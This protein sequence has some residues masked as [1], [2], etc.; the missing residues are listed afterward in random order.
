M[1]G[2]IPLAPVAKLDISNNYFTLANMPNRF[3]L[4]EAH[5]TYAPQRKV[6]IATT[7]PGIDLTEQ[8]VTIN[9]KTTNFVWKTEGGQPYVLG[10]DYQV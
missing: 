9:N 5:F 8:Y 3:G 6:V 4:D 2:I 7:S 1:L 10:T